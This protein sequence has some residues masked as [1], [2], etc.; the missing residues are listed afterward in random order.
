MSKEKVILCWSGGKDCCLALRA[1][2][3]S[4]DY[5]V[6]AL[7]TTCIEGSDRVSAHGVRQE[8]LEQQAHSLELPLVRV[9]ISP[10]ASNAEYEARMNSFF[11]AFK[12]QGIRKVAFGDLFLEDIRRYRDQM[13]AKI[14]MEAIYPVWTH[15]TKSLAE[16][17]IEDGFK[18][19]LVCVNQRALDATF[20]G[21]AYDSSLLRDLPSTVDPCGENGEFHTFVFDGPLLKKRVR[22][23]AGQCLSRDGFHFS[24]L[25]PT[26]GEN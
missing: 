23:T 17:F 2:R 12:Q 3:R 13:L 15:E 1:L 18:A 8:L 22:W 24:D 9:T 4:S 11:S 21:R 20:A 19:V 10:N 26:A 5:E 6:A 7:V 16:T 14:Q 25:H